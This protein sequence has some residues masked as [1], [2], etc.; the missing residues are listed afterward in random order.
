MKRH[1]PST[2]AGRASAEAAAQPSRRRFLRGA[3]GA[4]LALPTLA[5]LASLASSSLARAAE[6]RPPRRFFAIK[7]YSTQRVVDWYPRFSGAGYQAR[8]F[9]PGNGKQDGTTI[10]PER[11]EAPH[12]R[13]R[14][15]RLCVGGRAP[16]IEL[17]RP[18][19]LSRVLG[20][21]LQ[22]H[23]PELLLIRGADFMPDTSH[24]DGG[25][26]GNYAGA[27]ERRAGVESWATIDQVLAFSRHVYPT[28][29]PGPRSLHLSLGKTNTC[30]FTDNGVR[31]ADI[32]QVQ[33]H[34]DPRTAFYEV[35]GQSEPSARRRQRTLV[36]QVLEDL[37]RLDRDPRLAAEDR[38]SLGQHVALVHELEASLLA[39][40]SARCEAPASPEAAGE[41]EA[42]ALART[43]AA[44]LE[45]ALGA[46]RCD[47]TRVVTLDVWQAVGRGAGPGAEDL[48]YAHNSAKGPRDWHERVHEFGR[49]EADRQ[50]LAINQWIADDVFARVLDGLAASRSGGR[51]L[52]DD[53]L[54]FWGNELG[55]NHH[56]YSVPALLAGNLQGRLRTG[57]YLDFIDWEAPLASTQENGPIV[58]GVPHNRL[59]VTLLQAFGLRPHE[60]E[61]F[62][63]PGYGSYSTVG[64]SSRDFAIDYDA[65]RHGDVLPGVLT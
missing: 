27:D 5:S 25:M 14:D 16:L 36:D 45:I 51:A 63:R 1:A 21:R 31:D 38:R 58:E 9:A 6:P 32:V 24:N 8:P 23:L 28:P 46:L 59:L 37:H 50:V 10:C 17:A 61:R 39:E 19:R 54:V 13:R 26:L 57:Q 48:A 56:N 49:P 3:G 29:P 55:M 15:G 7:S 12:A 41:L 11:L 18:G 34:T 60:Y 2:E 40:P 47:R 22:R 35:F 30:S 64:K 52:L 62:G 42:A 43:T 20:P 44:L 53:T 33:A 4:L 65:S